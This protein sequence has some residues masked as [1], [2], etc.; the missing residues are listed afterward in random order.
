MRGDT[1]RAPFSTRCA[2]NHPRMRGEHTLAQ[3]A[4][5]RGGGSSPHARGALLAPLAPFLR[6][7]IIPACAG[8]TCRSTPWSRRA[9]D[10]PRM[11]G[12]HSRLASPGVYSA[13]SYPHARGALHARGADGQSLWIIPACAGS[14]GHAMRSCAPPRDH[15]R[16][17]GEHRCSMRSAS[18]SRG[19][20][21]HTRGALVPRQVRGAWQGIIPACAGSTGP[22]TWR[23]RAGRDHPRMRGE[24]HGRL[25]GLVA[26]AGLSPHARGTHGHV[27]GGSTAYGIIPACAGST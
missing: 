22:P 25:D 8:S 2:R 27:P 13:G 1:T 20:S 11:R 23:S 14:T 10:H 4:R 3:W 6:A 21:P 17:R 9:R 5:V 18:V 16:M 24:H 15:P 26:G 12:E 7:G 19:S